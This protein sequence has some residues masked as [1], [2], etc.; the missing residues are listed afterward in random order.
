MLHGWR[1][2]L[3]RTGASPHSAARSNLCE[4]LKEAV[5]SSSPEVLLTLKGDALSG[6]Y[7]TTPETK[8]LEH[9]NVIVS[10]EVA[11]G[12]FP[13]PPLYSTVFKIWKGMI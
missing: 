12:R 11:A 4:V 5:L 2:S 10:D 13:P 9:L 3:C 7:E 1:L 8:C 6:E